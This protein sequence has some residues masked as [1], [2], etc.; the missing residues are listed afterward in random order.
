M[1]NSERVFVALG[2]QHATGMRHIV[3]CGLS[4]FTKFFH[5]I[6]SKAQFSEKVTEHKTCVSI[7]STTFVWNISHSKK[8]WA[9]YDQ[10]CTLVF[11]SINRYSCQIFM[12]LN[13]VD[14][15]SK[16][17]LKENFMKILPV[18]AELFHADGRTDGRTER[19]TGRHDEANSRFSQFCERA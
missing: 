16:N 12:E 17:A 18:E 11:M 14:R 6:S 10:R 9:R 13:T 4:G 2:I 1:T 5:I 15:F 19:Q 7:L 8:N 3:I